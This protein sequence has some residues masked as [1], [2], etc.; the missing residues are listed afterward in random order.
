[1]WIAK[2]FPK[3]V[4]G[5]VVVLM[6]CFWA[7]PGS[8]GDGEGTDVP[9]MVARNLF[10]PPTE[11]GSAPELGAAN[12]TARSRF[13][14]TGVAVTPSGAKALIEMKGRAKQHADSKAWYR[15]G[16]AVGTY[17]LKEIGSNYVVLEGRGETMRI[18]LYGPEKDRPKPVLVAGGPRAGGA[19]PKTPPSTPTAAR[20]AQ[21]QKKPAP[22]FGP[23]QANTQG[24]PRDPKG[25]PTGSKKGNL[26]Q[27]APST[28]SQNNNPFFHA[29]QQ[30]NQGSAAGPFGSPGGAPP[31][32]NPFMQFMNKK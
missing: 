3:W 12:P 15:E 24:H 26:G 10:G 18:P 32:G 2:R 8:A 20:A 23:P 27:S 16:D 28:G 11:A 13:L 6:G 25:A 22:V 1:M 9:L 29:V 19:F 14:F 31:S 21:G 4:Y 5:M 7:V 30:S 17:V